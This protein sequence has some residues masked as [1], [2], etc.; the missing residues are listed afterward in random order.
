[1]CVENPSMARNPHGMLTK[2]LHSAIRAL[3][4]LAGYGA[5][6]VAVHGVLRH[7]RPHSARA[8]GKAFMRCPHAPERPSA[9]LVRRTAAR[10]Y[11]P[12]ARDAPLRPRYGKRALTHTAPTH[13]LIRLRPWCIF[14]FG[15]AVSSAHST[16]L[17]R[18]TLAA[19]GGHTRP[20]RTFTDTHGFGHA[21]SRP[22]APTTLRA[23]SPHAPYATATPRYARIRTTALRL[24]PPRCPQPPKSA[25]LNTPTVRSAA[26]RDL[27]RTLRHPLAFGVANWLRLIAAKGR[28][29]RQSSTDA[30]HLAVPHV[31]GVAASCT[32]LLLRH[33]EPHGR[34]Q[35]CMPLH[36]CCHTCTVVRPASVSSGG[37]YAS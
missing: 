4:S 21:P 14:A 37:L 28:W 33:A 1:M 12:S 9:T 32:G 23:A 8:T 2:Y 6:C 22:P 31:G 20:T 26:I 19:F 36:S 24:R 27:P 7:V 25:R 17:R 13:A 34:W 10:T 30:V 11:G 35:W 15:P 5:P 3:R 18:H 16:A 29:A